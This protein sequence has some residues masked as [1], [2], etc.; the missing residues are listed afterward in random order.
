MRSRWLVA[1]AVAASSIAWASPVAAHAEL[2]FT[3]P[4]NGTTVGQPVSEISVGFTE[5]VTLVGNGFEVLTPDGTVIEPFPVTDDDMTFRLPLDP[6]LGG[7]SVGVRYEV[8]ADDGHVL[9]G[10]FVFDV[11]APAPTTTTPVATTFAVVA[12][13]STSTS[14]SASATVSVPGTAPAVGATAVTSPGTTVAAADGDG[15]NSGTIIAV[16]AAVAAAA[17]AFLFVRSRRHP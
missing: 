13:T 2:D 10:S 8:A 9:E 17:A 3:L 6:P 16:A 5:P 12:S 4:G 14:T 15:S 1:G 7:G 11:A